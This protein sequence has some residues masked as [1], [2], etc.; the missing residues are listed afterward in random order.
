MW[1]DEHI[2]MLKHGN[3]FFLKASGLPG[4]KHKR[5]QFPRNGLGLGFGPGYAYFI[6]H[7]IA[8]GS[9]L[10][11]ILI[12]DLEIPPPRVIL[13]LS[14]ACRYTCRAGELAGGSEIK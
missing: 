8:L 6:T 4:R 2:N 1:F 5:W 10:K 11:F 14:V 3:W 9:L 12:S 7:N 13:N